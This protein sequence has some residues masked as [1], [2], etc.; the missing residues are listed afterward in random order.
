MDKICVDVDYIYGALGD[1]LTIDYV[2]L[3]YVLNLRR[4]TQIWTK[5][6]LLP[7]I[8]R[9]LFQKMEEISSP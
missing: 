6:D 2:L 9:E 8:T 4:N 7:L 3:V 5:P 1:R